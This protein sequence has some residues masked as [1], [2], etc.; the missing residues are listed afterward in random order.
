MTQN[1][2]Y[3]S[4]ALPTTLAASLG[5]SGNPSVNSV[6]G[7][8]S[9]F[10]FTVLIDWGLSTQEAISVTSAPTGVGPFTLP[11]TRGIDGTVAQSH[12]QNAIV[13]HGVS[14]EDYNEPQVHISLGTSGTGINVVHGLANGSSVVGTTDTQTL[15]NK[16]L[17]SGTSFSSTLGLS[18]SSAT[19][20]IETVTN[21]H[22]APS[23]PNVQWTANAAAD[24]EL[25]IKVAADTNNR[26]QVDSNGKMQWGTGAAAVDTDLYRAGVGSL[27]T[28]TAF[29][30]ASLAA[31]SSA[32]AGAVLKVTNTH[33]TPT[34][35][36]VGLIAQT[37]ADSVIG[38][39]VTADTQQRL[40]VDSNGKHLW[41]TGA[42][43]GDS[44]LYRNAVGEL[45][46]DEGLTVAGSGTIGGSQLLA[47]GAGVLGFNNAG[48]AP[49]TTPSAG[50]VAYA[51]SGSMKWRGADGS[52][53]QTGSNISFVAAAGVAVTGTSAVTITGLTAGLG[54][55]TYLVN[56]NISY[57]PTGTIGSTTTFNFSFTGTASTTALNWQIL[58]QAASN[59]VT[60]ASGSLT[61]VTGAMLSQS[62]GVT[63]GSGA[64]LTITG[65]LIVSVA[66]TL[67][68]TA[69]DTTSAD[70]ITVN[71]GSFLELQPIA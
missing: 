1:R 51:K 41:G 69:T 40:I 6:T 20:G 66:G 44:N 11:C 10:P 26:M 39:Q 30:A 23:A 31:S 4:V 50:A 53:Y 35:P 8:P 43:A 49:T 3:S 64:G 9:S 28:D 29:T 37:A 33:T 46:T 2:F 25:G 70:T 68:M 13:V 36:T 16:T 17:G 57:L 61:T 22:S 24:S 45:K 15:T 58:Q 54:A 34:A 63:T 55:G 56:A 62:H 38:V 7:L 18:A 67:T 60:M 48:T 52:D 21:T 65:I 59:A 5:S 27:E 71:G 32:A 12:S 47:G 14:A 42:A 19:G